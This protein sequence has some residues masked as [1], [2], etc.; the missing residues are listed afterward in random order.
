MY[1]DRFG[2]YLNGRTIRGGDRTRLGNLASLLNDRFYAVQ[3][4]IWF[5]P[6]NEGAIGVVGA[7]G[8]GLTDHAEAGCLCLLDSDTDG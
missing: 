7:I 5:A 1:A 2:I 3:H 6:G 4:G 8:E